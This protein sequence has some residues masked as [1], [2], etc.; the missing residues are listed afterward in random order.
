MTFNEIDIANIYHLY[1]K[2]LN[3]TP[4]QKNIIDFEGRVYTTFRRLIWYH[5]NRDLVKS[6][7]KDKK[8]FSKL[9]EECQTHM[10]EMLNK[11]YEDYI[12]F[13]DMQIYLSQ[14]NSYSKMAS[15]IIVKSTDV[16][17]KLADCI[18]E[19]G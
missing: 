4:I 5:E 10:R 1:S 2:A 13:A 7:V 15:D 19:D 9:P 8:S 16:M 17:N 18:I 3:I 14:M 11:Y 12:A 6:L